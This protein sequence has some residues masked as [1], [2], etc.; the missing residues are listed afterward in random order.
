MHTRIV[1]SLQPF[2]WVMHAAMIRRYCF[3]ML[4]AFL[5]MYPGKYA[6]ECTC[7]RHRVR[8]HNIIQCVQHTKVKRTV[9]IFVAVTR[10]RGR[11]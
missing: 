6:E 2:A 11:R 7:Y 1:V 10:V 5:C 3:I 4:N 8:L 9:I